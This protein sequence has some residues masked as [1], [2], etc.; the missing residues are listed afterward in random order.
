MIFTASRSPSIDPLLIKANVLVDKNCRA[1]LADF[2][3]LTFVSD[4]TNPTN[5]SSVTNCGTTRW[6]SPELL[7]PQEFGFEHSQ[8]TNK[9][10]CYALGMVILEVLSEEPPFAGDRD[11][12]VMRRVIG[13]ERPERPKRAWFTD[14]LWRTLEQCWSPQ[15]KDRPSVEAVLGFLDRIWKIWQPLPP[16]VDNVETDSDESFSTAG[17]GIFILLLQ[18]LSLTA[19]TDGF[20]SIPHTSN[21][22]AA[23]GR[24]VSSPPLPPKNWEKRS[25]ASYDDKPSPPLPLSSGP[26]PTVPPTSLDY[27]LGQSGY[28]LQPSHELDSP[29]IEEYD[30]PPTITLDLF[31]HMNTTSDEVGEKS[32]PRDGAS[33]DPASSSFIVPQSTSLSVSPAHIPDP[34]RPTEI[35]VPIHLSRI[36]SSSSLPPHSWDEGSDD[37]DPPPVLASSLFF[38][39]LPLLTVLHPKSVLPVTFDVET[40]RGKTLE[41]Q[42]KE[43]NQNPDQM[44]RDQLWAIWYRLGYHIYSVAAELYEKSRKVGDGSYVGFVNAVLEKV[45]ITSMVEEGASSFGYLIYVQTGPLVTRRVVDTLPGDIIILQD[46]KLIGYKDS[47]PYQEHVGQQTPVVAII[48]EN[49]VKGSTLLVFQA[50]RPA[51]NRVGHTM[52]HGST[53]LMRPFSASNLSNTG[54]MI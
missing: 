15:P 47:L 21:E 33:T 42:L 9:S 28:M 7:Y 24:P 38:I 32:V 17:E 13:G 18:N 50:G 19:K 44:T 53:I 51:G 8:P 27:I 10:D 49:R 2:G 30:E 39:H 52:N 3:L 4:P 35:L 40:S 5:A 22:Q 26:P 6:M 14:D 43:G 12:I 23:I 48:A 11:V 1:R 20:V 45:P 46:A 37:P 54:W 41:A 36:T 34:R 25:S 31:R 29:E 16:I